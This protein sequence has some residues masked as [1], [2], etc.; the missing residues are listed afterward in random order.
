[1]RLEKFE[2]WNKRKQIEGTTGTVE[3]LESYSTKSLQIFTYA[4]CSFD[5]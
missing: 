4:N 2:N 3:R 1:M 5:R